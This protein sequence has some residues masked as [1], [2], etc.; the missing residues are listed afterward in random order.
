MFE[1]AGAKSDS[2]PAYVPL[3]NPAMQPDII[4][5]VPL[6]MYRCSGQ[7]QSV[8]PYPDIHHKAQR[9]ARTRKKD[10]NSLPIRSP[11]VRSSIACR[12][13]P[14]WSRTVS[15]ADD[16]HSDALQTVRIA[17]A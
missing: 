15:T 13:L 1:P 8:S 16:K 2:Q 4:A 6:L 9:G 17:S 14:S 7:A 10:R 11:T 5:D 3:S 12:V